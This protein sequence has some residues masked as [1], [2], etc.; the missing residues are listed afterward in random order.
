MSEYLGETEVDWRVLPEF[1]DF[2]RED[3]ALTIIEMYGSIDGAHHKDWVLDQVA[4]VLN[5]ANINVR[6]AKWDDGQS[7]IRFDVEDSERY[8]AWVRTI[9]DGED[10]P[11]IY[12]YDTG[13]AP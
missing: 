4:R 2:T 13:I 8:H 1:K 3:W 11:N 5:G 6:I 10:G 9:T 7:E 12:S